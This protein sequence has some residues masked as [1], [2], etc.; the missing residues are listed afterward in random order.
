MGGAHGCC[1]WGGVIY[2]GE[3][4]ISAVPKAPIESLQPVLSR[5]TCK[6]PACKQ[7]PNSEPNPSHTPNPSNA[8]QGKAQPQLPRPQNP[9]WKP[10]HSKASSPPPFRAPS[11]TQPPPFH[12]TSHLPIPQQRQ[13]ALKRLHNLNIMLP[14]PLQIALAPLRERNPRP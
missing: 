9:K 12:H 6:H 4:H 10:A 1:H 7:S 3:L 11:N 2:G 13:R 5:S 8:R 14:L